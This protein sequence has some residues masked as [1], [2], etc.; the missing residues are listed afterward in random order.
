MKT[1]S[2]NL[3]FLVLLFLLLLLWFQLEGFTQVCGCCYKLQGFTQVFD[4]LL[5]AL[6]A[7]CAKAPKADHRSGPLLRRNSKLRT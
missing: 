2:C 3:F 1:C 5:C 7:F 4:T 6:L